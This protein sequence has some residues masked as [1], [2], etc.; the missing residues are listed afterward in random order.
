MSALEIEFGGQPLV[1]DLGEQTELARQYA[2][3]AK[4]EREQTQT[5]GAQIIA[6]TEAAAATILADTEAAAATILADTQAAGDAIILAAGVEADR[7]GTE[8]D[9]A[10]AAALVSTGTS[11]ITADVIEPGTIGNPNAP[12]IGT[13]PVVSATYVLE[14]QITAKSLLKSLRL[15]ARATGTLKI[16]RVTRSGGNDTVV[17]DYP[18]T[19]PATGVQNIDLTSLNI[20]C[21]AG[22]YL[23][24]YTTNIVPFTSGSPTP[25]TPYRTLA[26]DAAGTAPTGA[27]VSTVRLEIGI[28][29]V[30]LS[31]DFGTEADGRAL[32]TG[33][34]VGRQAD[35]GE[36]VYYG[37]NDE[38][39]D[40]GTTMNSFL[41]IDARTAVHGGVIDEVAVWGRRDDTVVMV[42][43]KRASPGQLEIYRTVTLDVVAGQENVWTPGN[44]L[45]YDLYILPGTHIGWSC[46][47]GAIGTALTSNRHLP[48]TYTFPAGPLPSGP[49]TPGLT[50]NN[51]QIAHRIKIIRSVSR[52]HMPV[53]RARKM[54]VEETFSDGLQPYLMDKTG[55]WTFGTGT[56][57]SSTPGTSNVLTGRISEGFH[58][59]FCRFDFSFHS[60]DAAAYC[61]K[62]PFSTGDFGSMVKL[63]LA[64]NALVIY[65]G[66]S[67]AT[68]ES[69]NVLPFTLVQDRTYRIEMV[70][71]GR[72][73][74]FSVIDLVTAAKWQKSFDY[75]AGGVTSYAGGLMT[76]KAAVAVASGTVLFRKVEHGTP[77]KSP[78][79][80]VSGDSYSLMF[81]QPYASGWTAQLNEAMGGTVLIDGIGG[82]TALSAL[83]RMKFFIDH[84]QPEYWIFALGTNADTSVA[85]TKEY[86]DIAESICRR[87]GIVPIIQCTAPTTQAHPPELSAYVLS[88]GWRT[89]RFDLALSLNN[90]GVTRD[91]SQFDGTGHPT[92]PAHAKMFERLKLDV[93]EL[94]E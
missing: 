69:T 72:V 29:F 51:F 27:L 42:L 39:S 7:S 63:D 9:R 33:D 62:F 28:D 47:V 92:V 34:R 20:L 3:A 66:W 23:A 53:Q 87:A 56:A 16:K 82:S 91:P 73:L 77:I 35:M 41:A 90:D 84:F 93:P 48:F 21:E 8:A 86:Y 44:G 83:R 37:G 75:S 32:N 6:D 61:G 43:L 38:L 2:V 78:R 14:T 1:I 54:L 25:V 88:K 36:V 81:N 85:A 22:E 19:I 12:V 68:V 70:R 10:E 89:V 52:A 58:H 71:V 80:M 31:V 26:G 11:L 46:N 94:F 30:S 55:T 40:P 74:T 76:G 65:A 17:Q 15:Y 13:S 79:V 49:F 4:A 60:A 59:S 24:F 64:A 45:P 5:S 67:T 18:V 57:T 50:S